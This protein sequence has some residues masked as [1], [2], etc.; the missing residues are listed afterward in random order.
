MFTSRMRG[1]FQSRGRFV[2]QTASISAFTS[3]CG[4][5]RKQYNTNEPWKWDF[6]FSDWDLNQLAENWDWNL[7]LES[8]GLCCLTML[9]KTK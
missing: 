3:L 6:R 2:I 8:K 4:S 1:F 9:F 5:V 7:F